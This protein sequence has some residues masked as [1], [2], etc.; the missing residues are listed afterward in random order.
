M[1]SMKT[2][3]SFRAIALGAI[4]VSIL[5]LASCSKNLNSEPQASPASTEKT[6]PASISSEDITSAGPLS[7]VLGNYSLRGSRTKYR[8]QA[9]AQG[10]NIIL[11]LDYFGERIIEPLRS[12][13]A[14][15]CGYGEPNLTSQGWKYVIRYNPAKKEILLSPNDTMAAAIKPNSFEQL[16]AVYDARFGSFTFQTRYTDSD[17]NENEVIDI[18]NKE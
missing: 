13:K 10:D 9:N 17:G 8:G 3:M 5:G 12:E 11:I 7:N 18:L 15:T 14:L 1:I 16:A 6:V 4:S 2:Q